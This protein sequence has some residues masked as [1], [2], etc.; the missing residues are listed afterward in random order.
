MLSRAGA[1]P[2]LVVG[3]DRMNGQI[4]CHAWVIVDGHAVIESEV[5]LLR[6]SP[7]LG[8]GFEGAPLPAVPDPKCS[9]FCTTSREA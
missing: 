9:G 3:F 8:F 5:N 7:A 1:D 6:F 2:T 4:L